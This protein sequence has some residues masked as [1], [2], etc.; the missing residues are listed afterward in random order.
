MLINPG[1]EVTLREV[2]ARHK[3]IQSSCRNSKGCDGSRRRL[4]H[5]GRWWCSIAL[6]LAVVEDGVIAL[7]AEEAVTKGLSPSVRTPSA[8][9]SRSNRGSCAVR[10]LKARA[11]LEWT[12]GEEPSTAEAGN[13]LKGGV[14][15]EEGM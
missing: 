5:S 6:V 1:A 10:E 4:T 12:G 3:L 13:W 7:L 11:P 15:G 8:S 14:G 2:R 9:S